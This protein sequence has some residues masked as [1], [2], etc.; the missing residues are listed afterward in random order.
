MSDQENYEVAEDEDIVETDVTE[1]D[2][3]DEAEGEELDEFKASFGDPST[4]PE[5]VNKKAKKLK[6]SKDGGE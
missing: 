6:G 4:V 1:E 3:Q 2:V 5:P